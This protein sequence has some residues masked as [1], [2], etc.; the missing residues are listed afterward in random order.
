MQSTVAEGRVRGRYQRQQRGEDCTCEGDRWGV[1][2]INAEYTLTREPAA[3]SDAPFS[4]RYG[5]SLSVRWWRAQA[6]SSRRELERQTI[7]QLFS[8]IPPTTQGSR[9]SLQPVPVSQLILHQ[10][11]DEGPR[12][13][14]I[15]SNVDTGCGTITRQQLTK[16]TSLLQ[17]TAHPLHCIPFLIPLSPPLTYPHTHTL[18][19]LST[20]SAAGCLS[21]D[22]EVDIGTAAHCKVVRCCQD[23]NAMR[24]VSL[25]TNILLKRSL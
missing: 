11:V 8:R 10:V 7:I 17:T 20:C 3:A 1:C 22:T 18:H 13:L 2:D 25:P 15:L 24:E 19:T 21:P 14:L 4:L 9:S 6:A 16:Q 12:V 23:V 5:G